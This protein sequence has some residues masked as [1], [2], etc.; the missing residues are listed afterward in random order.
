MWRLTDYPA[1]EIEADLIVTGL[2]TK[3]EMDESSLHLARRMGGF[4]LNHLE[5]TKL[6]KGEGLLITSP[7]GWRAPWVLWMGLGNAANFSIDT[8]KEVLLKCT[9]IMRGIGVEAPCFTLMG[10]GA[11]SQISTPRIAEEILNLT[12]FKTG[13]LFHPRREVLYSLFS[14][15]PSRFYYKLWSERNK[16]EN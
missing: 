14:A 11:P 4:A 6:P 15:L 13:E 1:E 5:E 3:R 10:E 7:K 9:E 12:P 16:K 2:Y 8:F